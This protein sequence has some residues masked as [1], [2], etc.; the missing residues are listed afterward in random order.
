MSDKVGNYI[1]ATLGVCTMVAVVWLVIEQGK[2]EFAHPC[3]RYE[4]RLVHV[5]ANHSGTAMWITTK[6]VYWL[7]TNT[8]AHDEWQNE[9]VARK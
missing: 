3:V 6:Q 9:C 7:A 1:L 4:R 2:W 8:A 5:P